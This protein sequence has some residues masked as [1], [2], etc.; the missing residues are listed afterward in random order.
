MWQREQNASSSEPGRDSVTCSVP[1]S[2]SEA[3]SPSLA[4]GLWCDLAVPSGGAGVS[5][6]QL[7]DAVRA[8]SRNAPRHNGSRHEFDIMEPFHSS[9]IFWWQVL[10]CPGWFWVFQYS[11]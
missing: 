5:H 3:H 2:N 6:S 11:S 1:M 4:K 10:H 7:V 8:R 9:K